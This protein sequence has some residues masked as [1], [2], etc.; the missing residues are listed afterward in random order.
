MLSILADENI[1]AVEHYVGGLGKVRRFAGRELEGSGLGGVDV[2]LVRSVTRVNEQLLAGSAVRFVGS[3]TSGLDH[4][5]RPCLS[6][7]GV[8]FAHAP[9]ANANSVVEYVLAAIAA[10]DDYLERLLAGGCAGIIGY[11][12]I[13]RAVAGRFESL[14]IR[15]RVYDPWLDQQ[16]IPRAAS[17]EEILR[18]DV[19]TLH[20]ELTREQ[21]WPSQRLFDA[22]VLGLLGRDCLLINA[23]RGAVVDNPA[24][25]QQLE[26]GGGPTAVLDVWENEPHIDRAL[27]PRVRLGTPHIAGYSLDGKLLA[28]RMV[29]AAMAA[30][31][32]LP[33]SDPGSAAG[34]ATPLTLRGGVGRAELLRRLLVKR[35]DISR[36]D[37]ALR[38]VTL[39]RSAADAAAGFDR[40]RRDYPQR[41]EL[42]GSAVCLTDAAAGDTEMVLGLGCTPLE[43][44]A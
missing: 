33:W 36:D 14:G 23:S 4:V 11:G 32:G 19:I 27:L 22:G 20:P 29:V 38:E 3:A 44:P 21:P 35:Y 30:Q 18:C 15:H 40:L 13:G 7:L 5:D 39:G 2:L 10:V 42:A 9:G 8:G 31:L 28:T 26:T 37:A 34:R 12:N 24:L 41:R 43:G 17:L 6:R 25:R 1:P 16:S